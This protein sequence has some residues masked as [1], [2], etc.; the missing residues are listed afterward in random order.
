MII[1]LTHSKIDILINVLITFQNKIKYPEM[2]LS[3]FT[4]LLKTSKK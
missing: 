2:K 3:F 1:K 4:G